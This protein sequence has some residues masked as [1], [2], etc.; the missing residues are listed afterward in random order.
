MMVKKQT[1]RKKDKIK[2]LALAIKKKKLKK[3]GEKRKE[4]KTRNQTHTIQKAKRRIGK[5]Q[6][7]HVIKFYA[8]AKNA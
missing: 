3:K 4:K 1:N 2:D 5:F 6:Y 8:V 7:G